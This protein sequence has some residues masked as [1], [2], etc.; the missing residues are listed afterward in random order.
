MGRKSREKRERRLARKTVDSGD[1]P[2]ESLTRHRSAYEA[3]QESRFR[4]HVEAINRLLQQYSCRDAAIALCVSELWPANAGSSVKHMLTWRLLLGLQSEDHGGMAITSYD[5]FK[6]FLEALYATWPELPMLEDFSPETDWG[7][8]KVRLDGDFVPIFYGSCLERT[9][10]FIEAFRITYADNPKAQAHMDLVV[11]L[12]AQIIASIRRLRDA[13]V[14]NFEG[15]HVELP[16]EEFWGACRSTVLSLEN[17]LSDWREVAGFELET[18]VGSFKT[19]VTWNAF[20]EA[21]TRGNALPHLAVRTEGLWV[22][23]SVR[24]APGCVIEHWATKADGEVSS[25][26]HRRLGRFVSERFRKV[27]LGPLVAI[28]GDEPFE[29]LPVSCIVPTSSGVYLIC[30]CSH[31]S[32]ESASDATTRFYSEV[33]KSKPVRFLREDGYGLTLSKEGSSG[34]GADDF[35]V[36]IVLTLGSVANAFLEVPERPARLLPLADFITIFDSIKDLDELEAFW[37]FADSNQGSLS[38]FS[39]AP[40]DLYASFKDADAL[41]VEGAESPTQIVL[42][43]QWGTSW[44]FQR[45][46]A[47]WSLAPRVFPDGS[48]GWRVSPGTE[49]VVALQSRNKRQVAY[50]TTVGICTIQTIIELSESSSVEDSRMVDLVAQIVV[51]CSYRCREYLADIP[52]FQRQHLLIVCAPDSKHPISVNDTPKPEAKKEQLVTFARENRIAKGVFHLNFDATLVL[53]GLNESEDAA[54]EV[55]CLIETIEQCHNACGLSFPADVGDRLQSR[56]KEQARYHVSIYDRN[57][58]VPDYVKPV[59]PLRSDYKHARKR[60]A[61][62]IKT[63]GLGSG[64]YQL[65]DAKARIDPAGA[66]LLSHIES[67]IVSLERKQ[68][69]RALVEQHDAL[70]SS[71]RLQILRARQSLAHEVEYDRLEAIEQA[72]RDFGLAA[73]HYRYLLEKAVSMPG[74]GQG[75]VSDDVL[76]ELVALVDWYMV[77]RRASDVLHNGIDVGGVHIDDSYLPEVFYSDGADQREAEFAREYAKTKLEIESN[78]QD[79]VKDDWADLLSCEKVNSAFLDDAGFEFRNL[80]TVLGFLAQAQRNGFGDELSLSYCCSPKG[81]VEEI[82]ERIEGIKTEEAERIIGFLTLSQEGVLKLSGSDV[83]ESD[84]PHWE[85]RKRVHRYAIRPLVVD[86]SELR[87]GAETSSR[88]MFNWLSVVRDGYLPADFRWPRVEN[89][90]RE[91]KGGIEKQL[92]LRVADVFGRH[93]PY[94][95]HGVDFFRRFKREGFEDVGDF[96]VL[97]YWTE[98]NLIVAVECKYNQPAYTTKDA[99]RLRDQIFGASEDDRKGQFS[100]LQRRRL[101]LEKNR[102]RMIQLLNWPKPKA[103]SLRNIEV[104]VSRDLYYWFVHPPYPVPTQFVRVDALDAWIKNVLLRAD[105]EG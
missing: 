33:S 22:P 46:A 15:G 9:P 70:L 4:K 94:V 27:V 43:P 71:E 99:R 7:H 104:Y 93:T 51:D 78:S 38:P 47:F 100:R 40:A 86:G 61:S 53:A 45:L 64:R 105:K 60:L 58:D 56:S 65:A 52:L 25:G 79:S 83:D 82:V 81:M 102:A 89:V 20:G 42:D 76:R 80:I 55:R 23:M 29:D 59:I 87:W 50:S 67:K 69:L 66:Q 16:S 3:E 68:L 63:L 36:I 44:R 101:F 91:I 6:G 95:E 62:E 103:T 21:A 73:R 24:S 8:V 2:T 26:A 19:P 11:A 88:A 96:D 39:L 32:R 28:I 74:G 77:L 90:T 18:K 72:R 75:Y 92:E 17:K 30:A 12:Q 35:Q 34:P 84:V 5:E 10:D 54:F 13:E 48:T 85:H 41:L 1:S 98:L 14:G 57:V 49:G 37:S 97:A 31:S